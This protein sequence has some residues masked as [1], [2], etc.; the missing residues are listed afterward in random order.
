MCT[1]SHLEMHREHAT[2]RKEDD[3]WRDELAVWEREISEAIDELPRVDLA[4]RAQLEKLQRYGASIR[5]HELDF[6]DHEHALA[7]YQRG[8]T[9]EEFVQAQEHGRESERHEAQRSAHGK[10]KTQQHAVL[11][12]WKLLFAA[13]AA[14]T[15]SKTAPLLS[16]H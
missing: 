3:L 5:L 8:E 13:L 4:L 12:K 2:W 7:K 16:D 1:P 10:I 14:K 9:P 11:T 15:P 6:E